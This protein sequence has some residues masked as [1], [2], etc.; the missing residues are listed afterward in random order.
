MIISNVKITISQYFSKVILSFIIILFVSKLYSYTYNPNSIV[1]ITDS[2]GKILCP[3]SIYADN[4]VVSSVYC[5]K[6]KSSISYVVNHKYNKAVKYVVTLTDRSSSIL[7]IKITDK[8]D[9]TDILP[10]IVSIELLHKYF[11]SSP[12]KCKDGY[13]VNE[14]VNAHGERQKS[15]VYNIDTKYNLVPWNPTNSSYSLD[16]YNWDHFFIWQICNDFPIL[17]ATYKSD[18][19]YTVLTNFNTKI[20]EAMKK[21]SFD[22]HSE[23]INITSFITLPIN[24]D[25][26]VNEFITEIVQ[27]KWIKNEKDELDCV[28][29]SSADMIRPCGTKLFYMQKYLHLN[30]KSKVKFGKL[31]TYCKEEYIGCLKIIGIPYSTHIALVY[32]SQETQ[33]T[34]IVDPAVSK[35]SF[36]LSSKNIKKYYL[37]KSFEVNET[38]YFIFANNPLTI[39]NNFLYVYQL[40]FTDEDFT[41]SFNPHL[42]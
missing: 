24:S 27:A 35:K 9:P 31:F 10:F 36:E 16:H 21:L 32:K 28:P 30:P 34:M 18:G 37:N 12:V 26:A 1:Y 7:L 20:F 38:G 3:G 39:L 19:R 17:Y 40:E 14:E 4:Y 22:S 11:D 2:Y 6:N 13:F 29:F 8:F 15:I 41:K 23:K 42:F 5:L 25:T 33:N